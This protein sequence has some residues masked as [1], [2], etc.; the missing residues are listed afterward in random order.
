[1][2]HPN[3]GCAAKLCLLAMITE[4]LTSCEA[5]I[6]LGQLFNKYSEGFQPLLAC[7]LMER[8]KFKNIRLLIIKIRCSN[9]RQVAESIA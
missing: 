8:S 6:I 1:M 5:N 9:I 3:C 7:F 2:I 4:C